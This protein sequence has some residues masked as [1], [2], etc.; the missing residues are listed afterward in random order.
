MQRVR[1]NIYMDDWVFPEMQPK[2]ET[3][4][5]VNNKIILLCVAA[6]QKEYCNKKK[7]LPN[8]AW[9]WGSELLSPLYL[10]T[11][12]IFLLDCSKASNQT[13]SWTR[14]DTGMADANY[15]VLNY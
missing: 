4:L 9:K 14:T 1:H 15:E 5:Q 2:S 7:E 11:T 13:T 6:A 12:E 10:D 3:V 8:T